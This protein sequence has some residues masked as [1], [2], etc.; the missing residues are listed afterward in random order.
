M[1]GTEEQGVAF[2]LFVHIRLYINDIAFFGHL[3][4]YT[5]EA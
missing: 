5:S 4:D 1:N 2:V 3:L